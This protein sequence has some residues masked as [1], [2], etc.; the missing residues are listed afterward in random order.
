MTTV[1][2]YLEKEIKDD[3][4]FHQDWRKGIVTGR[5]FNGVEVYPDK[6]LYYTSEFNLD[7]TLPQFVAEKVA[8]VTC[9]ENVTS[10][11]EAGFYSL[12]YTSAEVKKGADGKVG[13]SIRAKTLE[14]AAQLYGAIRF[15]TIRP[16]KSDG[17]SGA[18]SPDE[19][20]VE[21]ERLKRDLDAS[22]NVERLYNLILYRIKE[23][24]EKRPVV[25]RSSI[26]E[27]INE[28]H[29]DS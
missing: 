19:L 15:G 8:F 25:F 27:I 3:E 1:R 12:G 23:Y 24:M 20:K 4:D 29:L 18:Q 13:I 17:W 21:I 11:R 26:L 10:N 6:G 16:I 14:D 2:V 5:Q 7:D 9:M 28:T 22:V